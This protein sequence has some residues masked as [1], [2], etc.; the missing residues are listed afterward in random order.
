MA[1]DWDSRLR[2]LYAIAGRVPGHWQVFERDTG[3]MLTD[4]SIV[5]ERNLS[6]GQA[7]EYLERIAPPRQDERRM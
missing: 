3:Y 5:I 2:Q 1:D 7:R 4:G 6:F